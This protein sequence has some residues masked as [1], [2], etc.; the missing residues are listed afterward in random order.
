MTINNW[1]ATPADNDDADLANGIDWREGQLA[2]TVNNSAR[3]MMAEIY[4]YFRDTPD[5][6]S[7]LIPSPADG[8]YKLVAKLPFAITI[9]NTTTISDSGTCTA[10]FKIDGVSLGGSANSVS[11]SED[12]QAHAS[13]NVAAAGTDISLTVSSNSSCANLSFTITYTRNL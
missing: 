13:A 9:T 2:A 6:I 4:K 7:G 12:S 5:Y 8:T 11:S 3:S 1:S 10:T